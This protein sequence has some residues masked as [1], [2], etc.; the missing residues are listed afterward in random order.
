M[1]IAAWL[2]IVPLALVSLLSGVAQSFLTA[3]GLL[4]YHWVLAKLV[5]TVIATVVLLL[6]LPVIDFAARAA[7]SSG[8]AS[9]DFDHA[10]F[11]LL[12]HA[13]GGIVVL[14]AATILAIYKP[15]GLIR[16]SQ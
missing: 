8:A 6:K 5:L 4:R 2:V 11:E 7:M 15:W 3:W 13:G 1:R 9:P 10:R 12:I 14:L 16:R